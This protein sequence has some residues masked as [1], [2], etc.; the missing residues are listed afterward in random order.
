MKNLGIFCFSIPGP[1]AWVQYVPGEPIPRSR[2]NEG[3][4]QGRNRIKRI[5]L[6]KAF[7][8][9]PA[10]SSSILFFFNFCFFLA[11]VCFDH[12]RSCWYYIHWFRSVVNYLID[13]VLIGYYHYY[14]YCHLLILECD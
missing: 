2:P 3:S 7:I 11:S 6:R 10:S 9:V 8:K 14:Y 13:Q 5:K 4:V 12:A 1:Y